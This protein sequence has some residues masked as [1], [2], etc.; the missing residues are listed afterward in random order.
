[1]IKNSDK[2]WILA[3]DCSAGHYFVFLIHRCL[4]LNIFPFPVRKAKP[5]GKFYNNRRS[6][7]IDDRTLSI[8]S[9]ASCC[10]N[11]IGDVLFTPQIDEVLQIK[12]I[13]E[14]PLLALQILPASPK[15][16]DCKAAPEIL[17]VV[18]I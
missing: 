6:A 4:L 12:K 13:C 7:A 16:A 18:S 14:Y 5:I 9:C 17:A 11:T 10:A 1:V 2:G 8:L 15:S 3:S